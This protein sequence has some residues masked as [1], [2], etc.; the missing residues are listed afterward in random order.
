MAGKWRKERPTHFLHIGASELL[1][2]GHRTMITANRNM[3]KTRYILVVKAGG[4]I[5]EKAH[6]LATYIF[7]GASH[8]NRPLHIDNRGVGI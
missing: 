1:Q 7:M 8:K 5:G 2:Q 3:S 6:S 4:K